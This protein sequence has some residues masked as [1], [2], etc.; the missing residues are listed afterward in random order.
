MNPWVV[1]LGAFVIG[2][3]LGPLLERITAWSLR[4]GDQ[5]DPVPLPR[6]T[7]AMCLA[8]GIACGAVVPIAGVGPTLPAWWAFAVGGVMVAR[9]D[10]A[11]HRIPDPLAIGMLAAGALLLYVA[12]LQQTNFD[13]YLRG[14][15]A[16]AA[17]FFVFMLLSFGGRAGLGMGDVKLAPT[18]GLYLGY[19][20]WMEVVFGLFCGFVLG[21]AVGIVI[22]LLARARGGRARE[23]LTTA[24]PFG[25]FLL[26]GAL[27]PVLIS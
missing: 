22:V 11:R 27:V 9:A 18:L 12:A 3:A 20:G 13:S 14:W 24:I 2:A 21:A 7:W 19:Y 26:V 15:I 23:A 25:P 10:L 16:A 17:S 4:V 8:S 6:R 1:A 5:G